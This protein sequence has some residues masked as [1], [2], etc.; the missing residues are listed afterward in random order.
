MTTYE[1]AECVR[2]GGD[3]YLQGASGCPACGVGGHDVDLWAVRNRT[4]RACELDAR[5]HDAAMHLRDVQ[6]VRGLAE[7]VEIARY[8]IADAEAVLLGVSDV[9]FQREGRILCL[10]SEGA[11]TCKCGNDLTRSVL[12]RLDEQRRG[13]EREN[14]EE[15]GE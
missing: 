6:E 12:R 13:M 7:A 14:A 15:D 3:E 2:C 4:A 11:K 9:F 10:C 5:L 1:D 8:L